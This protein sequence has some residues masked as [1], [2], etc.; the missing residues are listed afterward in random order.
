M[1]CQRRCENFSA[2]GINNNMQLSP[3]TPLGWTG[4]W[5]V[6]ALDA[7]ARAVKD[8]VARSTVGRTG[9]ANVKVLGAP[10]ADKIM[11]AA[12]TKNTQ[13]EISRLN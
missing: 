10:G 6:A 11:Y 4:A 13:S 1:G 2:V 5:N 8:D 9:G 7:Q 12:S 3:R